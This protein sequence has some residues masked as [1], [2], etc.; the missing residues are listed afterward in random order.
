MIQDWILSAAPT[1]KNPQRHELLLKCDMRDVFLVVK[2]LGKVCSRPEKVKDDEYNFVIYLSQVDGDVDAKLKGIA[3]EQGIDPVENSKRKKEEK[4]D[5]QNVME[6]N[7]FLTSPGAPEMPNVKPVP[8]IDS[9]A[10]A[11][12]M[13]QQL[14]P[15]AMNNFDSNTNTLPG[16]SPEAAAAYNGGGMGSVFVDPNEPVDPYSGYITESQP[17]APIPDYEKLREEEQLKAQSQRVPPPPTMSGRSAVPPPPA[18]GM[19]SRQGGMNVPPPPSPAVSARSAENTPKPAK[20]EAKESKKGKS[21]GFNPFGSSKGRSRSGFMPSAHIRKS[22]PKKTSDIPTD[23]DSKDEIKER[24]ESTSINLNTRWNLELPLIP[25]EN[26]NSMLSGSHNRFAHAAAMAVI[27]TPG[28]IYN[29]LV[30]YGEQSTGKTHFVNLITEGLSKNLG[31]DNIFVTSGLRLSKGVDIAI[32]RGV[33]DRMDEVISNYKAIIIDDVHLMILTDSNKPY[34]SKWLNKFVKESKQIV[35]STAL[36]VSSLANIEEALDFQL[37]QGWTV[38]L[39]QTSNQNYKNILNQLLGGMNV[40]IN[41]GD[42]ADYFLNKRM[43]FKDVA[44]ILSDVR[45]LEKFINLEETGIT[46]GELIEMLV[47]MHEAPVDVPNEAD[48]EQAASWKPSTDEKWLKWGLM[49]PKGQ[50]RYA[51]YAIYTLYEQAKK[52]GLEIEWQ[53][54]FVKDYDPSNVTAAAFGIADFVVMQD[55]NGVI[56]LGPQPATE[57]ADRESDFSHFVLN[58][59][60]DFSLRSAWIPFERVKSIAVSNKALMDLIG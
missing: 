11:S 29:P 31:Y 36:P 19:S 25:T 28:T 8:V 6:N 44:S 13:G 56:V 4:A 54:V 23:S 14:F 30:I 33:I 18:P 9:D 38:E 22:T 47:G 58:I 37:S 21:K 51:Y 5:S 27:E 35:M 46:Q 15:S 24:K 41:E 49:F 55:V 3:K 52:L 1:D 34:I 53:Q 60:K 39:K 50:E 2:E 57:A 43:P 45:K 7:P 59:L 40:S 48:L 42:M 26:I 16:V 10:L 17:I 12:Q 20:P 32:Q